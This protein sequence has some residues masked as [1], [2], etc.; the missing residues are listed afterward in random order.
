MRRGAKVTRERKTRRDCA[1]P[2]F[3]PAAQPNSIERPAPVGARGKPT[4]SPNCI[5]PPANLGTAERP[6]IVSS[7]EGASDLP[8]GDW[9]SIAGGTADLSGS[10]IFQRWSNELVGFLKIRLPED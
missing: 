4:G 6:W 10:L 1:S 2:T 9:F 8:E 5:A 3:D 7:I